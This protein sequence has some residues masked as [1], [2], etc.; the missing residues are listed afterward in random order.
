M[1]HMHR[2][3]SVGILALALG[4]IMHVRLSLPQPVVPFSSAD[5]PTAKI[6][7]SWTRFLTFAYLPVFNFR[8]LL[9]PDVLSFDW[10]MDAIPRISSLF[11]GKNV[12]SAMFYGTLAGALWINAQTLL[13]Q[14]V[15]NVN[16][17]FSRK[18]ASR[19]VM[20][21]SGVGRDEDSCRQCKHEFGMHH[22][23]QCRAMHNNNN[24]SSI[25]CGCV[26]PSS[27]L[28]STSLLILPFLPATNLLFYVGFVVAERILYLP[29]VGYCLLIGLGVGKLIDG[30]PQGPAIVGST[31]SRRSGNS[32]GLRATKSSSK[33]FSSSD[34][35]RYKY[36]ANGS[37][38][39]SVKHHKSHSSNP[40]SSSSVVGIGGSS[41]GA[42]RKSANNSGGGGAGS[43][44]ARR[45][46][47]IRSGNS[48]GGGGSSSDYQQRKRQIILGCFGA[49]L[50]AYSGK[51]LLRN[52]DWQDEESLF[53]S[54]IGVNPPKV[55]APLVVLVATVA[56]T[57]LA[58]Q[59]QPALQLGITAQPME[60]FIFISD[61][62]AS[63]PSP[64]AAL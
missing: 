26:Y 32:G 52:L 49:L 38:G 19:L 22:S 62:V 36:R 31:S 24:M 48:S 55:S 44:E 11:D 3:R 34:G 2:F 63:Q 42:A 39:Q 59:Q 16:S 33:S 47:R 45:A 29:S 30:K 4:S 17:S 13:R 35:D 61:K 21:R 23:N 25:I 50:L 12:L 46:G 57:A 14:S 60:R 10:G 43:L 15:P 9:Y 54:A 18:L 53:R 20:A 64:L 8:L 40:T 56:M 37:T 27:I 5:N 6:G 28:I 1:S 51:T 7:S 58:G 41:S